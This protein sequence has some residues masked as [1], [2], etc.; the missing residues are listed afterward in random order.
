MNNDQVKY[1]SLRAGEYDKIYDKPERQ[2]DLAVISKYLKN[3]FKDKRVMEIA[4][5]TGYWTKII[6][7]TAEKILAS[8]IN[9]AVLEIA[10]SK[11]YKCPVEFKL[12]DL[13]NLSRVRGKFDS[14]FA[15]FIWSHIPRKDLAILLEKFLAKIKNGGTAIFID[16]EY[17][18]GNSTPV[19]FKD[20]DDNTYQIRKLQDGSE[21][22]VLKNY[23]TDDE[24][25]TLLKPYSSN[26]KV[27][28]LRYFWILRITL[29]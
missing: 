8:D 21:H 11:Q 12:D 22:K 10:R 17:V 18:A 29:H 2:N 23:P 26:L 1:Y 27:E 25:I 7:E 15:G 19:A 20:E 28:R 3:N 24:L 5:G 9:P 13:F 14:G 16:N 6:S 4:C